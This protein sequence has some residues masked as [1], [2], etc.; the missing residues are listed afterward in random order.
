MM[1]TKKFTNIF[2]RAIFRKNMFFLLTLIVFISCKKNETY[3]IATIRTEKGWGYEISMN[4]KRII[5]Q[6]I[7]PAV[8]GLKGFH[9]E[10]DA[11]KVGKLVIEKLESNS[12]PTVT[13]NDLI[14]LGVKF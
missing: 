8:E 9:S 12:P 14:L 11:K 2:F 7:I 1:T 5:K 13:K 3:G 6:T 10:E 4:Q